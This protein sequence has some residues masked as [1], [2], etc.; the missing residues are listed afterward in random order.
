MYA[1]LRARGVSFSVFQ[2]Y[3]ADIFIGASIAVN[4]D[5]VGLHHR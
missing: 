2:E 5:A 4:S 3:N 1:D